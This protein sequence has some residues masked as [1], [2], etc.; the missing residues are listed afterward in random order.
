MNQ[1]LGVI[2]GFM[3]T[4][5]F[6]ALS[7]VMYLFS[8]TNPKLLQFIELVLPANGRILAFITFLGLIFLYEISVKNRD[9]AT[10]GHI[11]IKSDITGL[12][13]VLERGRLTSDVNAAFTEFQNSKRNYITGEYYIKEI[14]TLA[15]TRERLGVNSYTENKL[16]FL[17]EHIQHDKDEVA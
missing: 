11:E 6:L 4:V 9:L 12:R 16:K 13:E 1:V 15:D 8:A 10:K 3:S 14:M 5:G 7:I 17:I 2:K